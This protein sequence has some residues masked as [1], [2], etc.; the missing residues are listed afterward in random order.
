MAHHWKSCR[1]PKPK[2]SRKFPVASIVR[3][4][5]LHKQFLRIIL[6]SFSTQ[7]SNFYIIQW[8]KVKDEPFYST[9]VFLLKF[10]KNP[11]ITTFAFHSKNLSS[12]VAIQKVTRYWNINRRFVWLNLIEDRIADKIIR[13]KRSIFMMNACVCP[14]KSLMN[15][16]L[17]L[18]SFL[19]NAI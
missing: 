17:W 10:W 12:R 4:Q 14:D 11:K 7:L 8:A 15:L 19:S 9:L 13:R 18:G 5:F 2:C 6:K 16:V 3:T 1:T